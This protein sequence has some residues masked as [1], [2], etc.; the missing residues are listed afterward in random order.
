MKVRSYE[1]IFSVLLLVGLVL[2]AGTGQA[3]AQVKP[4]FG[5]D[6]YG[7]TNQLQVF[8]PWVGVRF[9]LS[10]HVSLIFRYHYHNLRYDYKT[11]D[12]TGHLVSKTMKADVN[13]LS[14]TLYLGDEKVFG[15]LN[16]SHLFGSDQYRGYLVDTGLEWRLIK[17]LSALISVYGIQE[18]SIL[19]H[20]EE[21]VRWINTYS[22]RL[23]VKLWLA[24]GLALNPNIHLIRNS[25]E[26]KSNGSSIGLIYSPNWWLAITGYFFRYGETA[27]Y[28]FHGNYVSLGLNFYF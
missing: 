27:F 1:K 22:T 20:P 28:V 16:F 11:F 4:Q 12:G 9:G 8:S 23:G 2:L 26:V 7:G 21:K 6:Y 15:Y 17:R 25:E 14:G 5:F 24:K 3:T 18:K 13:R 10:Y 19:W